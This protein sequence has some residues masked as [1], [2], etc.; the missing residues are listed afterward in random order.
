MSEVISSEMVDEPGALEIVGSN[1][2]G[3]MKCFIKIG[4][5]L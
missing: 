2:T 3:P 1:P 5:L 4:D